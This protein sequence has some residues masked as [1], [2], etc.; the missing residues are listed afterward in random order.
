MDIDAVRQLL[1]DQ[2]GAETW[3]RSLAVRDGKRGHANL[4]RMATSGI[5][6]D[7]LGILMDQMAEVLPTLS[8]ADMA[9]NNLE[10]FVAAARSPLST[11]ALFDRDR[12]ALPKLLQIFSTSQYLCD[13]LI[14]DSGS[15][16]IL[17]MTDGLPVARD[18]LVAELNAEVS[19]LDDRLGV[20]A[21]L[22]RF[23][24]RETLRIA[25]GD[26]VRGQTLD[27]VIKQ[28]SYLA[29]TVVSAAVR[30]ARRQ[31]EAQRGTPQGVD[32]QRSRFVVLALGKLGG[33]ELNYSSDIDLV[34][35]Y[36][37]DGQ[38]SGARSLTNQEFYE[39]LV[40]DVVQLLTEAT[41]LGTTYR[42]DLRLRPE[43]LQGPVV[44]SLESAWHYYDVKG[45]TWERQAMIKARSIAGD[46]ELGDEFLQRL[47]PWIYRRFLSRADI[48]GIKTLK[49]S[50]EGRTKTEGADLQDVKTGRGGIR[51]VEFV[52][53]FLQLLNAGGL[54]QLRTG[55]TLR[56]IVELAE[57]GCLTFQ[58]QSILEENYRVL[59]KI[60]H[61]LQIMFDLRT[62]RL[63]S[64]PDE[65]QKLAI[66]MGFADTAEQSAPESFEAD[67]R[68]RA[69]L[70]RK[71]LDHLLHDAF[72]SDGEADPEVD[73][74]N[75]PAPPPERIEE[76]L[77]RYGFADVGAA[78]RNLMALAEEKIRFLSTRRCR[79][80]LASIA[81]RLLRAIAD[82]PDPDATLVN[83][84]RV[85][86]SLGG[87]G[88]L[89]ELMSVNRA[90]LN[91]YVTL[92]AACPY[93][94]GIL[95]SNPGMIDE[96]MDSLL[97]R[98]LPSLKM[99][100][101]TLA[102]LC[103][104]AE[105]L[106][107]ILHSFKDAQHLRVGVRDILGKDDI[108][109]GHA[110]LSDIA[111]A[112][113]NQV[114]RSEYAKLVQ[115][116]GEPTIGEEA[117]APGKQ[118][119]DLCELTILALGK[120]GGRE[121][122]YH[123]DLDIVF[124]YEADGVT[125]HHQHRADRIGH[126][127]TTSNGHFFSELGQ[128]IIKSANRIGPYGRLYEVDPRLR[129]TGRSGMLAVPLSEFL[130]Y[131]AEST[132]QLW[133]RQ[134]LCK[135]RIIYG[136]EAAARQAMA[137]VTQAVYGQGWTANDARQIRQM[138]FRLEET[139]SNRNLKRGPGGTVDVEFVVQMLQLRHGGEHPEVRTPGTF[140]AL[141]ALHA[142]GFLAQDD[143]EQLSHGYRFQRSI[144]ARIRLMHSAA[145]HELPE[146][147]TELSKLAFL[148][149]YR[150]A[151]ALVE[152]THKVCREN[153]ARFERIFA[154][155]IG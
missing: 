71:I 119:G 2:R 39:R 123:S 24:H 68:Q 102:E 45:R 13:L 27:T 135:G 4:V 80:F 109:A 40:P 133:E 37:V 84:S 41:E 87:K 57:A 44:C 43:G 47:E 107:P 153:R 142:G 98:S 38:T 18:A 154:K 9:L 73:L 118:P 14:R 140:D 138:R 143:F 76:V 35:L 99:L 116:F 96:L 49:R 33:E 103:R 83:L 108:Q 21:A 150:S 22:R 60:E 144:E 1:D 25:Y 111:Q 74:V 17:R 34:C 136:T 46:R 58:E 145:R 104:G 85:S 129:P 110:A 89:W 55:N 69:E 120:L 81:P 149:G 152:E 52:I 12:T 10:R 79:H 115:K 126:G 59:R 16:D 70:N 28:I 93:L 82:T 56:A 8:D 65:T 67:Y 78:Y 146:D 105:D 66:R 15:Y 112:C 147:P 86:E 31:L 122:N 50:I 64:D 155:V 130:R 88:A 36:E 106:D 19:V 121:P 124:L 97:L 48:T 77:R 139:A 53:Q 23:K 95:T 54:P 100:E 61:R 113:L 30:F 125:V 91:L 75:D 101:E 132:G 127:E 148:L 63:P 131:F 72:E 92:C 29:D 11:A 117:E 141:S 6:L 62:H 90:S 134:S 51:D 151:D 128:R 114:T 7:L 32:V 5:T 3:L 137:V 26:I 42:V 94:S 20:M